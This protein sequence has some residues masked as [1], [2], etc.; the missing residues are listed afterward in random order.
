MKKYI[1]FFLNQVNI[2]L[3]YKF[4]FVTEVLNNI[5]G[6]LISLFTWNAIYLSSKASI[7][8]NFN[9][10][11]MLLYIII[12]NFSSVLFATSIITKLG[13]TVRTGKLTT[14][15]LRPYSILWQD[16]FE[17]IGTKFIY[18][19]LYIVYII[20]SMFIGYGFTY[21]LLLLVF[22]ISNVLMFFLFMSTLGTIGF[23]VI[24]VWPLRSIMNVAFLLFGGLLFPLNLL[25]QNIYL[26]LS[27]TPFALVGYHYTL[28][29]QKSVT[30]QVVMS[31]IVLSVIWLIIFYILYNYLFKKGLK[32]Y[33]G[34]GA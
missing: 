4:N 15:L 24:Q 27:K 13:A 1:I 21:T 14:M 11:Q 18:L 12:S 7:I 31:N 22:L 20:L 3:A 8:G 28:A 30:P 33:E 6:I 23:Y 25:P 29:L 19:L 34:M 16:F 10:N 5:I 2:R 26:I 32:K 17:F 9:K